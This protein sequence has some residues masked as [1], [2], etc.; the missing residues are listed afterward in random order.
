MYQAGL[1]LEGGGMKGVYT[2]GVLDYFLEKDIMFSSCYGVSA[3]ACHMA[4]Y[5][6]K[7]QGRAFQI[8]VDYLEDKDYCSLRNLVTTGDFFGEQMCYHRIPE[9]LNLYDYE[10]YN[11]YEGNAYAVVTNIETGKA[12]YIKINDMKKD[13]DAVR[14][15]ASLPLLSK[16]VEIN[17]KKYLDGGCA[18]SIPIKQSLRDGNKKNVVIMTKEV[19]YRRKMSASLQAIQLYYHKYP[20]FVKT[21][22]RRHVSYNRTLDFLEEHEKKGH[23]FIIRPQ[24]ATGIG[25]IEKDRSKLE[26]LYEMGYEEAKQCGE[27]LMEYLNT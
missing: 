15:S 2:A 16:P 26:K 18:D 7:Q 6:S 13:I 12:E 27:S 21:M 10:T 9:E 4:S 1:V 25:R 17:G 11:R 23:I 20:E 5:L 19:G 24:K 14:A 22:I 8:S 3:G